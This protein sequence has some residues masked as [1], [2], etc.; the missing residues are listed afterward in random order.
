REQWHGAGG[1][2]SR[3]GGRS[4]GKKERD[5]ERGMFA[6]A[7]TNAEEAARFAARGAGSVLGV[8]VGPALPAGGAAYHSPRLTLG[9]VSGFWPFAPFACPWGLLQSGA[10]GHFGRTGPPLPRH[11]A[12]PFVVRRAEQPAPPP[13]G[14]ERGPNGGPACKLC[15]A[16]PGRAETAQPPADEECTAR[17]KRARQGPAAWYVGGGGAAPAPRFPRG[18][19]GWPCSVPRLVRP[20]R[21]ADRATQCASASPFGGDACHSLASVDV[22][23]SCWRTARDGDACLSMSLLVRPHIRAALCVA[24]FSARPEALTLIVLQSYS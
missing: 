8:L 11:W 23:V 13:L 22:S 4:R 14:K 2:I 21:R 16:L 1:F 12:P 3:P 17:A 6:K 10:S 24:P 19:P 20:G 15:R 18:G 7:V 5:R 9:K